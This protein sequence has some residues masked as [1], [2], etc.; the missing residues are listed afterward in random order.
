MLY[1]SVVVQLIPMPGGVSSRYKRQA[2]LSICGPTDCHGCAPFARE[3][4]KGIVKETTDRPF[5]SDLPILST[6][7]APGPGQVAG[8]D[9]VPLLPSEQEAPQPERPKYRYRAR[10]QKAGPLRFLGHLE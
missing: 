10:F 7:A 9:R 5:D 8:S 2:T 1:F 4:V 3:C 6:P